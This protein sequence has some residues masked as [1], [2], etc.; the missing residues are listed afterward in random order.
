MQHNPHYLSTKV[1]SKYGYRKPICD[2][3]SV[4]SCNVSPYVCHHFRD[5]R[6]RNVLDLDFDHGN[7]LKSFV[8]K[9]IERPY[10][11]L[12][13]IV[14]FALSVTV[15][16]IFTVNCAWP[17]PW[18]LEWTTVKYKYANRKATCD[19]ICVGNRAVFA[20]SVTSFVWT[21][22]CHRFESLT[23]KVKDKDVDDL[24]EIW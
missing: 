3:I 6:S 10:P 20:L 9:P 21:H 11:C 12:F 13:A 4:C 2:C 7:E 1:K 16:E 17:W 15:C 8:S 18:P 5:I 14:M 23:L 22:K 24:D 19:F